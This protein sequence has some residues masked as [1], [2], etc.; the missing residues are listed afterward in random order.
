MSFVVAALLTICGTS[1]RLDQAESG[2][3]KSVPVEAAFGADCEKLLLRE[4]ALADEEILVAIYSITRRKLTA[5][6]VEAAERGVDV[7][8]KYD[9][10]RY[11]DNKGM[12]SAI[13]YMKKRGV[14]CV[15][16]HSIGQY[17]S[18]HHKF[19]VIDRKRTLTGSFNYT[20]SAVTRNHENLVLIDS[21]ATAKAYV[22]EFERV[23]SAKAP[24]AIEK[25]K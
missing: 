8:V 3:P 17:A 18:M 6:L 20:V 15:P 9:A 19:L 14:K 5:A 2:S 10:G 24:A 22:E 25:R 1:C 11:K 13:G 23:T 16:I 12:K 4:I 7:S 21:P